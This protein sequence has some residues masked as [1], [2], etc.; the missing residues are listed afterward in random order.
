MDNA[1]VRNVTHWAVGMTTAPRDE[2]TL[3][4]SVASL[5]EAGWPEP[6][7]FMEP[8][9]E[10][11][12]SLA[13]LP[14]SQRDRRLG[15][16]PNWFLGLS[17]LYFRDPYAEAYFMCQDDVIVT[18]HAPASP[19]R[20]NWPSRKQQNQRHQGHVAG[21]AGYGR[22]DCPAAA[23]STSDHPLVAGADR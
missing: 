20:L 11:P 3:A 9:T 19:G 16:F 10:I 15:A 22:H 2:P 5:A 1:A 21:F 17:E 7:L 6:R 13:S 8:E 12:K 4:R 18:V 14:I 23:G